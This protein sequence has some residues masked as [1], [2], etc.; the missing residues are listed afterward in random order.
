MARKKKKALSLDDAIRRKLWTQVDLMLQN[1]SANVQHLRSV[2]EN[3]APPHIVSTILYANPDYASKVCKTRFW[4]PLHYACHHS[5]DL[6]SIHVVFQAH[7][8]AVY[9][10]D[11]EGKFPQTG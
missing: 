4:T 2:L 8:S 1:K 10:E 3:S 9:I 7:P 5:C 11:K 6:G